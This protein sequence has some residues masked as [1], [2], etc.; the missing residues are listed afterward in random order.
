MSAG[1]SAA[2]ARAPARARVALLHSLMRK[3]EKMI[4]EAFAQRPEA[5]VG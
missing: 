5:T 4:L 2:V 1:A 3:D